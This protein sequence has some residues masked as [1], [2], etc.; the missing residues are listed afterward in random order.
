MEGILHPAQQ[1]IPS[2]GPFRRAFPAIQI[3]PAVWA[4]RQFK[5]KI[6]T[7]MGALEFIFGWRRIDAGR[8]LEIVSLRTVPC[9]LTSVDRIIT[10]G[11]PC[12]RFG[13]SPV[14]PKVSS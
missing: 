1:S 6:C 3:D 10:A 11:V 8:H 4:A 14:R 5:M 2:V 13:P 7:A 12:R 9:A